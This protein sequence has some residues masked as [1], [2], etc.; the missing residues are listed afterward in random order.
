[1]A[2]ETADPDP[3]TRLPGSLRVVYVKSADGERFHFPDPESDDPRPACNRRGWV[4]EAVAE[5]R[6]DAARAD[7]LEVCR[8]CW[9]EGTQLPDKVGVLLG[10]TGT[11]YHRV[12]DDG[13]KQ[14]HYPP[15]V[16]DP[17]LAIVSRNKAEEAGLTPCVA[18][19]GAAARADLSEVCP[20]CGDPLDDTAL[21]DHLNTPADAGCPRTPDGDSR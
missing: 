14:C 12:T 3:V 13:S 21:P 20:L 5:T 15:I 19:F 2:A 17:T 18:C 9:K 10:S 7:G 4:E 6:V 11:V 16:S 8:T 1:M